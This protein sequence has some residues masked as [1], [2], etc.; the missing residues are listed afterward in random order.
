MISCDYFASV[1]LVRS[2]MIA[3]VCRMTYDVNEIDG[4]R[5]IKIPLQLVQDDPLHAQDL[6]C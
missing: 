2:K 4:C 1:V 5:R 3:P 6:S